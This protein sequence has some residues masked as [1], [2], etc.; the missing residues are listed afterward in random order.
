MPWLARPRPS[1]DSAIAAACCHTALGWAEALVAVNASAA[2]QASLAA[3][4]RPP[5]ASRWIG[6]AYRPPSR[7]AVIAS[8]SPALPGEAALPDG[9]AVR[10][11]SPALPGEAALP[12]GSAVRSTSPALP[13]EAALPD[14]S[15]V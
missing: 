10:S 9:S 11:T 3:L 13:G 12:D 6:S 4:G 15:A 8:T 7:S 14:G 2:R 5:L 1:A